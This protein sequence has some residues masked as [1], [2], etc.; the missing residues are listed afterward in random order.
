MVVEMGK[1]KELWRFF[2]KNEE[3]DIF[4]NRDNEEFD[5]DGGYILIFCVKEGCSRGNLFGR[6]FV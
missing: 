3:R 2:F 4:L 6:D 5:E 1:D